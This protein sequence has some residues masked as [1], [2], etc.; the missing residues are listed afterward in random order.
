MSGD[1]AVGTGRIV[2]RPDSAKIGRMAV[3][4]TWRRRGVGRAL[5]NTLIRIA[6]ERQAS[7]LVLHAQV[8]AIPFYTAHGFQVVGEEFEE[9]GIPHRRMERRISLE[10]KVPG[11]RHD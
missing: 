6:A 9:A 1:A 8:H 4:Q 11:Q 10:S 2:F 5:L 3:L 7:R